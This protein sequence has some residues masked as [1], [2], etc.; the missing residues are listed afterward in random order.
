MLTQRMLFWGWGLLVGLGLGCTTPTLDPH[1]DLPFA[2]AGPDAAPEPGQMGP[3]AVGVRAIAFEDPTRHTNGSAAPRLLRT[4]IWYP[5]AESARGQIENYVLHDY[6]SPTQQAEIPPEALGNLETLAQRDAEIRA[7]EKFPVVL[8]SH[9][10]GGIRMQS[11]FFTV[12]LASH[13]FIVVA[14]DH[15]GDTLRHLLDEGDIVISS[16]ADSFFDR[17]LDISFLLNELEKPT[18]NPLF[19]M[20]DLEKVGV[21]GHSFG[22]LTAFRSAGFDARIDAVLAHTPVGIGL[23]E[24][25]LEVPVEDFGIPVMIQAGGMDRTLPADM[26]AVSVWEDMQAPAYYLMLNQAGHFTFSDLCILDVETIDAALEEID[27][28]N[29]LTDGCGEDNISPARAFPAIRHYSIAFF[30]R[31]LRGSEMSDAHFV[32]LH[33]LSIDGMQW[34]EDDG[35]FEHVTSAP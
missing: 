24:L 34:T 1:A 12:Q 32:P 5:A 4:E 26:H 18:D 10:K 2:P 19:S 30:N 16:T 33:E 17:P 29:V 7:N 28:S 35:F 8:F 14:P 3:Y 11:T 22:A 13:G 20:M 6:L 9:G 23:V 31:W 27:A 15:E 25:G 21:S